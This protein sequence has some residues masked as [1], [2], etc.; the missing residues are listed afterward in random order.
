VTV[1][2]AALA[3]ITA[4]QPPRA[5][6]AATAQLH[7]IVSCQVP[8]GADAADLRMAAD[9]KL[10]LMIAISR[11][12]SVTNQRFSGGFAPVSA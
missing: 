7:K 5:T 1:G 9:A 12:V 10:L 8:P 4:G 2:G 3:G 6:A 11:H